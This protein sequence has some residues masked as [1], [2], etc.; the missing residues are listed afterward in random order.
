MN[1]F[2]AALTTIRRSPYQALVSITMVTVTFFVVYAFG[3]FVAGAHKVLTYFETQPQIIAFF[4]LET[5]SESIAEL[6]S[7]MEEQWYVDSVKI[8]TQEEA[9]RI[10]QEENKADP[11]LLELVTADI[12][13][14]SIEVAATDLNSLVLV[15]NELEKATHVEDVVYQQDIVE[16][17]S[18]WTQSVRVI[19]VV[20]IA[21][22]ATISFLIIMIIIAIKAAHKRNTIKIMRFIGATPWYIKAPFVVEGII[23]G[24][25]GSLLGFGATM[26]TLM[27]SA[28]WISAFLGEVSV[29]P[30]PT[31]FLALQV[32]AGTIGGIVLGG[33][34]GLLAVQ[35]LIKQ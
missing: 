22:L 26:A 11:L 4:E 1:A 6:Q 25:V 28:P 2:T 17:L 30:I 35:R 29:F 15:K 24:F 10:Y 9:L 23:Y 31:E 33:F 13:P 34:A 27:Y 19:G 14:A 21:T 3:F 12:L 5:P 20:A 7:K 18:S 32:G 8:V 16:T